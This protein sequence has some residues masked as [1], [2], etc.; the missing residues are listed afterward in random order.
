MDSQQIE[1]LK[2]VF[3]SRFPKDIDCPRGGVETATVGL[4]RAIQGLGAKNIHVVSL[5]RGIADV[6]KETHENIHLHRLGRSTW[7]CPSVEAAP[8]M[9]A[10]DISFQP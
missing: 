6:V 8:T 1:S 3:V 2:I 5:E 4:A 7:P 10:A 9:T